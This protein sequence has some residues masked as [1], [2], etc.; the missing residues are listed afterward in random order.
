MYRLQCCVYNN[1]EKKGIE[2]VVLISLISLFICASVTVI[3]IPVDIY[4]HVYIELVATCCSAV[5]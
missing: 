2:F 4:M 3:L 1:S 5:R